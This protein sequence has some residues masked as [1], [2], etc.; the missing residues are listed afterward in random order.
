MESIEYEL[1]K[2]ET[3]HNSNIWKRIKDVETL[4][5]SA[6]STGD[7]GF[8]LSFCHEFYVLANMLDYLESA[9]DV[10]RLYNSGMSLEYAEY[11]MSWTY[12]L[13]KKWKLALMNGVEISL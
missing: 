11:Y 6:A 2:I 12:R 5:E 4:G 7:P 10:I 8:I 1:K 13:L 9:L 3:L